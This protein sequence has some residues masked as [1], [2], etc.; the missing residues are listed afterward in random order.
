MLSK[1]KLQRDNPLDLA[2]LWFL[3]SVGFLFYEFAATFALFNSRH[4]HRIED[5]FCVDP[6]GAVKIQGIS[7]L[8]ETFDSKGL[9]STPSRTTQPGERCRMA[10]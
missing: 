10:V 9:D 1:G 2:C 4:G 3:L 5:G 7:G 6:V 8:A